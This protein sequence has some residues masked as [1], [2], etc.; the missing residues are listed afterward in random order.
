VC[1][2]VFRGIVVYATTPYQL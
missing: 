2:C 1:V